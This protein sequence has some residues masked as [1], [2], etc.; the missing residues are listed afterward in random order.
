[1]RTSDD[2]VRWLTFTTK[3]TKPIMTN[4]TPTDLRILKYS[5]QC[6]TASRF[7]ETRRR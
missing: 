7:Q 2:G 3:P 5:A 4:P 1:M 6:V